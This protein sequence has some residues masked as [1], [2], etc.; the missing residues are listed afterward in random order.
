MGRMRVI[1]QETSV[2]DLDPCA[3]FGYGG[4]KDYTIH[5]SAGVGGLSD[6][7]LFLILTFFVFLPLYLGGGM[8]YNYKVKEKRGIE[9]VPN[10]EFWRA[11]PGYT[12]V[13]CIYSYGKAKEFYAKLKGDE[14]GGGGM[15]DSD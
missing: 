1:A 12:K 13:G 14:N 10:L 2:S 15:Q 4:V 5:L 11:L 7:S 9:M 6:G 8:I 3:T